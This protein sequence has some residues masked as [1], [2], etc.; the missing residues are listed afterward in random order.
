MSNI[1]KYTDKATVC[2]KGNCITVYGE[3]AKIV[4]TIAV[5]TTALVAVALIGKAFK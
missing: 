4:T 2:T 3:A 1:T 5:V